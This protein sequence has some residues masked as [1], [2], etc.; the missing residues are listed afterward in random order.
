MRFVLA[1]A[2]LLALTA[3]SAPPVSVISATGDWSTL[4]PIRDNGSD[5]LSKN[6]ILALN[7]IATKHECSLP[8]FK[9]TRFDFNMSFAAQFTPDGSL[10][11]I[12]IPKLN[13]PKAEAVI[14]GTLQEMIEGG[15]YRPTGQ[16]PG[17]WYRGDLSFNFDEASH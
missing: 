16:S 17:G 13:C 14:G 3:A 8:G 7:D 4:P 5:H 12:V 2:L 11:Q 6:L 9:G 15:D 10:H 1:S